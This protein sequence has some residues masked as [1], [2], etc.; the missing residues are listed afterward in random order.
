MPPLMNRP[1]RKWSEPFWGLSLLAYIPT[2]FKEAIVRPLLKKSG[3]DS[4]QMK[5]YRPVSNLSFLSKLLERAAQSRLEVLL[6]SNDLMPTMQSAWRWFH[7]TETAVLKV[8]NDLLLAADN[9][10]VSALCLLD[11]AVAFDTVDHDLMMLKLECQYG[12]HDVVVD[13]FRSYLCGRT[14]RVIHG[15]KTSYIVHVICSVPQGL[16]LIH[17]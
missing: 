12:L 7:S 17:I 2:D 10:D 8:Y 1:S 9:G 16:S 15:G 5:N 13:W 11:L 4:T 14:Y 6:D 3:L